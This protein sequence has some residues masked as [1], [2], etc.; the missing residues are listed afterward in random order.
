MKLIVLDSPDISLSY[1]EIHIL[2]VFIFP[3]NYARITKDVVFCPH[4]RRC[5]D[6]RLKQATMSLSWPDIDNI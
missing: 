2:R 4:L 1:E 5:V 6:S 3:W